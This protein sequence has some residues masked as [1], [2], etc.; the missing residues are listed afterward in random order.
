MN[1]IVD[2]NNVPFTNDC[3]IIGWNEDG[4]SA[5]EANP[6]Y[7]IRYP[8]PKANAKQDKTPTTHHP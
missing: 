1:Y 2:I 5:F 7:W 4:D 6:W 8:L 3:I